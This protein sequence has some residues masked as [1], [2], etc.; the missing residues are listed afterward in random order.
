M[1]QNSIFVKTILV[2]EPVLIYLIVKELIKLLIHN[3]AM[4]LAQ[5]N[6]SF[7]GVNW[8]QL[9]SFES[10]SLFLQGNTVYVGMASNVI[11][12]IICGIIFFRDSRRSKHGK[13][14][15][16]PAFVL[17]A[18]VATVAAALVVDNL[19]KLSGLVGVSASYQ[20][21]SKNFYSLP[22]AVM[23]LATGIIAPVVEELVFRGLVFKRAKAYIGMVPAMMI[24]AVTFGVIH[25][26]LVQLVF[27]GSLGLLLAYF[28]DKSKNL[29]V[30]ILCHMLVNIFSLCMTYFGIMNWMYIN[31]GIFFG[32]L[33]VLTAVAAVI[34]SRIKGE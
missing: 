5:G 20:N 15:L 24:S 13:K 12:C 22:F 32:T 19:I 27:A 4:S 16:K 18:V 8:G 1:K 29:L 9:T 10:V 3:L 26:N 28:Y 23:F 31:Q 6:S 21:I 34:I 33:I 17:K 2:V 25:G 7:L 14:K 30:P 11:V